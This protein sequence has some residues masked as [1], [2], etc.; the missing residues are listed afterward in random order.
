MRLKACFGLFRCNV[1]AEHA[2][3][4]THF[5]GEAVGAR[6]TEQEIPNRASHRAASGTSPI[7][8]SQQPSDNWFVARR[9][10]GHS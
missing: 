9:C 8:S 3:K 5:H 2:R 1:S 10:I 4:L 6:R 7:D